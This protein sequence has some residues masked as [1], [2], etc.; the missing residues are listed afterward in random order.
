MQ[1]SVKNYTLA[2]PL[3]CVYG[4]TVCVMRVTLSL[5]YPYTHY[6]HKNRQ[7]FNPAFF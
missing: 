3:V 4:V 1:V 6:V 2:P 7:G 5:C